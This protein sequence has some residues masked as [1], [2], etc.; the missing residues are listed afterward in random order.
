[1][2]VD[3]DFESLFQCEI[4]LEFYDDNNKIPMILKCG[5]TICKMCLEPIL[6]KEKK[7]CPHCNEEIKYYKINHYINLFTKLYL[8]N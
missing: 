3:N 4:C 5:H 2:E 1:M 6:K 8:Y 7:K